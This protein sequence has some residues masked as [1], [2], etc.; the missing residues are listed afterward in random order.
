M[1]AVYC[2]IKI[3]QHDR[4]ESESQQIPSRIE[5]RPVLG[6][7]ACVGISLQIKKFFA[8]LN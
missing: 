8:F 6:R 4:V 3:Y 7:M 5:I 2:V 1:E